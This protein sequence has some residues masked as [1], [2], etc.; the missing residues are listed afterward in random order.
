M[1]PSWYIKLCDKHNFISSPYDI[2]FKT[3][4]FFPEYRSKELFNSRDQI[5]KNMVNHAYKIIV[6]TERSKNELVEIYN[7]NREKV[8]TQPFIPFLPSFDKSNN[9]IDHKKVISRL[10]L[11]NKKYIFYPAQFWAHKNHRYILDALEILKKQNL[12]INAVFCGN[13]KGNLD[14][15]KKLISQKKLE[16]NVNIFNFIKNEEVVSLYKNSIALVMPTF[17][18]RSTLPL[19]E[20]FYFKKPVFYSKNVLDEN[21]EQYVNLFDLENPKDLSNKLGNLIKNETDSEQKI[22]DA[23]NFYLEQCSEKNFVNNYQQIL[24]KYRYLSQRWKDK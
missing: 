22:N 21:L 3:D 1:G 17:V 23:Y 9:S 8:I 6:D 12:E 11:E 13:N 4:N 19:Y 5:V 24:E 7:C 16:N 10:G 20:A 2:N 18:A 14:Y 15:V